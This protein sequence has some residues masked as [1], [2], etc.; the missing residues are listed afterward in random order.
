MEEPMDPLEK[1]IRRHLERYLAGDLTLNELQDWLVHATS[2]MEATASPEAILLARDIELVLAESTS[3]YLTP[4][5]LRADLT[6]IARRPKAR[7]NAAIS[8]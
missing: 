6:E 3:G 5:E 1:A 8:V 7:A 4:D 2:N